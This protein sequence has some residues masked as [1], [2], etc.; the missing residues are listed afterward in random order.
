MDLEEYNNDNSISKTNSILSDVINNNTSNDSSDFFTINLENV[1]LDLE[2]SS[3]I[4]NINIIK[5]ETNE[6]NQTNEIII[7]F[8]RNCFM[9]TIA[10]LV[11]SPA[12][13]AVLVFALVY[14]YKV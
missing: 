6:S 7:K 13:I 9:Y 10:F 2:P 1:S 3:N 11:F 14:V 8:K 12:F 5:P 4:I